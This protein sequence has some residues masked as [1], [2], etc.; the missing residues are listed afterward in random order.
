MAFTD[1]KS[2][3]DLIRSA[4]WN[5]F[6]DFTESISSNH[7]WST[8]SGATDITWDSESFH[9]SGIRWN[10]N[11]QK[12]VTFNASAIAGGILHI[13]EDLTPQ[14][15]ADLD[16]RS[17]YG[18]YD[19]TYI[20]SQGYSGSKLAGGLLG[21]G[22]NQAASGSHTH[23]ALS[24][25]IAS[26]TALSK[27]VHSGVILNNISSQKISGGTIKTASISIRGTD[28]QIIR[29]GED[30]QLDADDDILINPDD[31]VY[32]RRDGTTYAL[33]GGHE[34]GLYITKG[35]SVLSPTYNIQT[36]GSISGN[37][38]TTY[39]ITGSYISGIIIR[40]LW[41]GQ[42]IE[43]KY[44]DSSAKWSK[45]YH[46]GN[47]YTSAYESGQIAMYKIVH[48]EDI[49]DG[50]GG[51][52]DS[53]AFTN[54]GL[55]WDGTNWVPMPSGGSGGGGGG[56]P[57][58]TNAGEIQY[59]V[60]ASTFG[61]ET[62]FS[63]DT[64]LDRLDVYHISAI[65]IS[66]QAISGGYWSGAVIHSQYL[67]SSSKYDELYTWYTNSS[68]R[69]SEY[70]ASGDEYSTAYTERG[71]QIAGDDLTWDGSNINVD[72]RF[73]RN[74]EDD[75]T[76]YKITVGRLYSTGPISGGLI[77]GTVIHGDWIGK[78]ISSQYLKSGSVFQSAYDWYSDSS[79]KISEAIASGNEY[80]SA[81]KSSQ[82]SKIHAYHAVISSQYIDDYIASSTVLNKFY[83]SSEGLTRSYLSGLR[84][85]A[86][87][88]NKADG[89]VLT[90][91]TTQAKW[92]AQ[93]VTA[94]PGGGDHYV[95]FNDSATLGGDSSFTWNDTT[96]TLRIS[97]AISGAYISGGTIRTVKLMIPQGTD[98]VQFVDANTKIYEVGNTLYLITPNDIIL[99]P[100]DNVVVQY[101]GTSWA[102]F[103]G[104]EKGLYISKD[105]SVIDP[106]Y[107]LQVLGSISGTY[108]ITDSISGNKI[109]GGT[110]KGTWAGDSIAS[111]YIPGYIASSTAISRFADSSTAITR[112]ADSSQYSTDKVNF[113]LAYNWINAS[114]NRYEDLLGSGNQYSM[115]VGSGNKYTSAYLSANALKIHSFHAL[116]SSSYLSSGSVY[117]NAYAS[118]QIA[119][120]D[121][122]H[123][124]DIDDGAG[125][126]WDSIAFKNSGIMWDEANWVPM[127]SG[128]SGGGGGGSAPGGTNAGDM[129]Y[130]VDA[131]TLGGEVTFNYDSDADTLRLYHLSAQ[132][133][134]SQTLSGGTIIGGLHY[135]ADYVV[136]RKGETYYAI[137]SDNGTTYDSNTDFSTLMNSA[138]DYHKSIYIQPGD[139]W[140][141]ST[142]YMLSGAT[143][144]GELATTDIN[145][146]NGTY[147]RGL[148][149]ISGCHEQYGPD[150]YIGNLNITVNAPFYGDLF[151]IFAGSGSAVRKVNIENIDVYSASWWRATVLHLH[152][153]G[154]STTGVGI[155][156]NNFSNIN[157]YRVSTGIRFT[158]D[159]DTRGWI[160][161]NNFENIT[162]GECL[163]GIDCRISD[164]VLSNGNIIGGNMFSNIII[165]CTSGN[166][167][168]TSYGCRMWGQM[169]KFT[170]CYLSD[171]QNSVDA[172]YSVEFM[173][174][175]RWNYME[176]GG[177]SENDSKVFSDEGT[178]NTFYNMQ[179]HRFKIPD[180]NV[181]DALIVSG[182][183]TVA[184]TVYATTEVSSAR[185][186]LGNAVDP[187][188]KFH[189]Q[190]TNEWWRIA[191]TGRKMIFD[192]DTDRDGRF[193]PF[194]RILV[195]ESGGKIG[196]NQD[197]PTHNLHLDGSLY[198]TTISSQTLRTS[199]HI[200]SQTG[201]YTHFISTNNSNLTA[202]MGGT[203]ISNLDGDNYQYGLNNMDFVSSQIISGGA[204][205]G[206]VIHSRYIM[207]SSK[208]DT[209]Y[210]ERGSQIG[211][212]N[213]TWDVGQE[214]LD[215][216]D[217]FLIN[218]DDDTTTGVITAAG[219]KTTGYV[220]SQYL[221]GQLRALGT[222]RDINSWDAT[223]FINSG[224]KW[225]GTGWDASYLGIWTKQAGGIYYDGGE[226]IVGHSGFDMGDY[227]LQVSGN[228]YFS[229]SVQFIGE[230]SGMSDPT[231]ASGVATK[232]YVDVI[233]GNLRTNFAITGALDI[234]SWDSSAWHNSSILWDNSLQKWKAEKSGA[235]T[236]AA[237]NPSAPVNSIQFNEASSFGGD[238]ELTWNTTSKYMVVAGAISAQAYSGA[239]TTN[240]LTINA[241]TISGLI[242]PTYASSAANKHYVDNA[243]SSSRFKDQAG[244]LVD[245]DAD[246]Y[247]KLSG[248]GTTTVRSGQ[249]MFL[250][251]TS[252]HYPADYV[253]W[254]EGSTYYA[255][256][257]SDGTI[258]S[259]TDSATL[260]DS[261]IDNIYNGGIIHITPGRYDIS[262]SGI[263]LG[264]TSPH[265]ARD[266]Q[267]IG[268]G[269]SLKRS[270]TKSGQ[271]GQIFDFMSG[272]NI[273]FHGLTFDSSECGTYSNDGNRQPSTIYQPTATSGAGIRWSVRVGYNSKNILFKDCR[274]I[275][276]QCPLVTGRVDNLTMD[277]CNI[278][279]VG[280][281]ALYLQT[282][283]GGTF[284][285]CKFYNIAKY[286]RGY[287]PKIDDHC[288]DL[289]FNDCWFEPNRD[290]T[291]SADGSS[292]PHPP[293]WSDWGE[294]GPVIGG[295]LNNYIRFNNCTF[296]GDN[297][298]GDRNIDIDSAANHIYF[299]KCTFKNH[300][301]DF[302]DRVASSNT[303][304]VT[305][306]IFE[307]SGN[308]TNTMTLPFKIENCTFID[309]YVMEP[310]QGGIVRGCKFIRKKLDDS[311]IEFMQLEDDDQ[312]LENCEF[313][314]WT[315]RVVNVDAND[316]TVK[317]NFFNRGTDSYTIDVDGSRALI[318]DN[319]FEDTAG[320]G[321]TINCNN[322]TDFTFI[323][324]KIL[325]G[326]LLSAIFYINKF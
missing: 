213:L 92:S 99:N 286:I 55:K 141:S 240:D 251:S 314:D 139:Y 186:T 173:D 187:V 98:G 303:T 83:Q 179:D 326:E 34:K 176:Y 203:L 132:S 223:N 30:L 125:G 245:H 254:K 218:N 319:V 96:D 195:I 52:W 310:P 144:R 51:G 194:E 233:S 150:T 222:A 208:Y 110:I 7:A 306:S 102:Q 13:I 190:D 269:A 309:P 103:G 73:L 189:E 138:I 48:A 41:S 50:A 112:F 134:S 252:S 274:F 101:A 74:Y 206:A 184:G 169:N 226:V 136:Y 216:D 58:G 37:N 46:S 207:S 236:G 318:A 243:L 249:Y 28:T 197:A 20:S 59:R 14:L 295:T 158:L 29:T 209:A 27:F 156:Y 75:S 163:R 97:G 64:T 127:P 162:I 10:K 175:S 108:I 248:Q 153:S 239:V 262:G 77:S 316:I 47:E 145:V 53:V 322:S 49:D 160:N 164:T 291:G 123:A 88:D 282:I 183:A 69:I 11:T 277:N 215:V 115:A 119:M 270:W 40:G 178:D 70:I 174:G 161:A 31:D 311:A 292:D 272:S 146:G 137:D 188:M 312:V 185:F 177:E 118:A 289:K 307:Y 214:Q 231:Y 221:S 35:T 278:D 124:G 84:D 8:V 267:I 300:R 60:D 202:Q 82:A 285:N 212:D 65:S 152:A 76:T 244:I 198:A 91:D 168:G 42:V 107:N 201:L 180:L 199:S 100:D 305:D 325:F 33:F 67:M 94:T 167:Y 129:Q 149:S 111:I 117:D 225:N 63:Y 299:D 255:K 204:W 22:D 250:I 105:G 95:Q 283:S 296:I 25:Y 256:K 23:D 81:Y 324:N 45:I 86:D 247:I 261:T 109:S 154:S 93:S 196:I 229:G 284:N 220:S 323:N 143:I 287:A 298:E 57:G 294:Y 313:Y 264:Y 237:G 120:Y 16:G 133:V 302:D 140:A 246:G 191:V 18:V 279:K 89:Y 38:I 211:G 280:E 126:G 9:G 281:H 90:Y 265:Y 268:Y 253:I 5:S 181:K 116:I 266:I 230:I 288:Y 290:R 232:H 135:P 147:S 122:K 297:A 71:S 301:L 258:T 131:S 113:Q 276:S 241:N 80:T 263:L 62:N 61:A 78:Q 259:G 121:I 85:V 166:N 171:W 238:A 15:G 227:K 155:L 224:I 44:L 66:A 172:Q 228:A 170:N 87:M 1:T 200:S 17:T 242:D 4:D 43:S 19:V 130:R 106:A 205:S 275:S 257:G 114:S 54:S 159:S 217:A 142:I 273:S 56:T 6:V 210:S 293:G 128:G 79:S 21:T 39:S 26:T 148:F 104:G 235:G 3:G 68:L 320:V 192:Y 2:A 317:G 157:S 308:S 32:I 321:L 260:L 234:S 271:A 182:N 219:F 24:H 72:D 193:S 165:G 36:D 12:W 315:H 151:Y 304:Y